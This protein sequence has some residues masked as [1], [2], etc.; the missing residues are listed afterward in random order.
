MDEPAQDKFGFGYL[1]EA[2]T[3]D[4]LFDPPGR[5]DRIHFGDEGEIVPVLRRENCDGREK[6]NE[7]IHHVISSI[8]MSDG[9]VRF[10][11]ASGR[12]MLNCGLL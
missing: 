6:A 10:S 5:I 11:T 1:F 2:E 12:Q 4:I 3:R 9:T 8:S 7:Y